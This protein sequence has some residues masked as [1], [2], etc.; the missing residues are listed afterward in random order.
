[1]VLSLKTWKS[2]SLPGL[3]RTDTPLQRCCSPLQRC[4]ITATRPRLPGRRR[5][6]LSSMPSGLPDPTGT[7]GVPRHLCSCSRLFTGNESDQAEIR[8]RSVAVGLTPRPVFSLGFPGGVHSRKGASGGAIA[9]CA[10]AHFC[11]EIK[12]AEIKGA[13]DVEAHNVCAGAGANSARGRDAPTTTP[14]ADE[15]PWTSRRTAAP[16]GALRR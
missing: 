11:A 5:C 12:G 10:N 13:G 9:I 6:R 16:Q 15:M 8:F 14:G 1:M 2:R 4:S 3:P 7:F